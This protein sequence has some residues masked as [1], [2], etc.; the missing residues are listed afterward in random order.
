M[1]QVTSADDCPAAHKH[2]KSPSGYL[3]WHMWAL[4][5]M[6]RHKQIKC[7]TCGFWSIFVRRA[8]GEHDYGNA[9]F[10]AECLEQLS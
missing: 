2:T 3:Q 5:K 10:E 1:K 9:E 8:G 7:P 4:R 6:R